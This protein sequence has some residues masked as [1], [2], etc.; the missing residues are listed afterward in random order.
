MDESSDP[1]THLDQV[2][3]LLLVYRIP[4]EPQRAQAAL[5]AE[6]ALMGG[7]VALLKATTLAG[8]D[9]VWWSPSTLPG[10]ASTKASSTS[11]TL[12]VPGA[13]GVRSRTLHLRRTAVPSGVGARDLIVEV[14]A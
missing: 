14:T 2:I 11:P 8:R 4:T 7:T 10:M 5:Q 6:I 3:W 1:S 13:Q 9:P 12:P